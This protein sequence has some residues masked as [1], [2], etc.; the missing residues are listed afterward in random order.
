MKPEL[1]DAAVTLDE[2]FSGPVSPV[3][4]KGRPRSEAVSHAIIEA[5]LDL[6]A[7]FGAVAEVSVEAV[8]ELSGVSKATIYRR[9]ASKEE[10]IAAAMES[11]KAPLPTSMP[12]TSLRDDLIH[13]G[14]SMRQT[15]SPRDKKVVKCIMLAVKDDPEYQRHHDRLVQQRRQFVRDVFVHWAERGE[16]D[17]DLDVDLAVA[18]FISPLLTIF[19]YGQY[20]DLQRP[21]TVARYVEHLLSGFGGPAHR[22]A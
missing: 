7:E 9:W 19:V 11:V 14:N 1:G 21:D 8:A 17:P 22:A 4:A 3:P 12:G 18:M 2:D 13:L 20:A 6:I 10:L 16:M 5:T 15:F